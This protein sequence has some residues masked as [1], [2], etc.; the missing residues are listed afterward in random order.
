MLVQVSLNIPM[1]QLKSFI[2][3]IIMHLAGLSNLGMLEGQC[4]QLQDEQN[5][6]QRC[7][8]LWWGLK[9]VAGAEEEMVMMKVG[10]RA[11]AGLEVLRVL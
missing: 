5:D 8:C 9:K 7:R 11:M 10:E 2:S 3:F 1:N 4:L 6:S